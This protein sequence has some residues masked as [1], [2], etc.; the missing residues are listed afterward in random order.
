[1]AIGCPLDHPFGGGHLGLA[2]RRARLDIH[3]HRVFDV[4]QVIG[5]VAEIGASTMRLGIAGRW[6]DWRDTLGLDRSCAT[7]DGIVENSEVL[8]DGAP[9]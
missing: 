8:F 2:H 4:D 3:D 6:I 5:G 1:M 9:W 7:E